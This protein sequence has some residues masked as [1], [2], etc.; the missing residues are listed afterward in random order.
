MV[1]MFNVVLVILGMKVQ[2]QFV[3]IL[4][5]SPI[6]MELEAVKHATKQ[7]LVVLPALMML[8]L[9]LS[10]VM[11]VLMDINYLERN[12]VI[13]IQN[14]PMVLETVNLVRTFSLDVNNVLRMVAPQSVPL[15][16]IVKIII[17]LEHN[18]VMLVKDL[19]LSLMKDVTHV[20]ML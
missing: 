19:I 10:L 5:K 20:G 6:L 14:S 16:I 7:F 17:F 4:T 3:V 8:K 12:V 2:E 15:V 13:L 1:I 11:N 9:N 18:V